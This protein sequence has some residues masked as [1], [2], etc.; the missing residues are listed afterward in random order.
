ME[1]VTSHMGKRGIELKATSMQL[2][3]QIRNIALYKSVSLSL[4]SMALPDSSGQ[5]VIFKL[6]IDSYKMLD[7][8]M[9]ESSTSKGKTSLVSDCLETHKREGVNGCSVYS[10]E[11]LV[12]RKQ[13]RMH[14]P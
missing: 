11:L 9:L 1:K 2:R 14:K 10:W 6:T 13:R 7:Y 5:G 8:E 12:S 4:F 3:D